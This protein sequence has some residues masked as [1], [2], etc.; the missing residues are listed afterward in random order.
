[1]ISNENVYKMRLISSLE[2]LF[3]EKAPVEQPESMK[4]SGLKGETVSFQAAYYGPG[5][6][7]EYG[8]IEIISELKPWIRVRTVELMPS[9]FPCNAV[10]DE[11]YLRTVPGMFPDLLRD[12]E[13]CKVS[14]IAN[15]WRALWIDV[16]IPEDAQAGTYDIEIILKS[17]ENKVLCSRKTAVKIVNAVLPKQKLYHTEWFHADCLADFYKME[18]WS[19]EYWEMLENFLALYGK[20]GMNMILTPVL[21]P[22]LD[23]A[24]GGERTTIQLAVIKKEGEMYAF[25]FSRL[26]RWIQLCKKHGILYFE[27][28]HLFTQWGQ[29]AHRR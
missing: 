11:N 24:V 26:K 13:D 6:I 1:M 8:K 22:P 23:T 28:S 3:P 14:V 18:P 17:E 15:Q 9:A 10:Y 2:K 20:R 29:N 7:K 19:E 16:E 27:I 4:L 25:D 5:S 12:I 21:T